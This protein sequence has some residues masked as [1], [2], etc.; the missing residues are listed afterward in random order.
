MLVNLGIG[1]LLLASLGVRGK[2][3]FAVGLQIGGKSCLISGLSLLFLEFIDFS[4]LA[5][6][7]SL[8]C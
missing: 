1:E 8:F 6:S 3:L 2:R 7:L 5:S 4:F